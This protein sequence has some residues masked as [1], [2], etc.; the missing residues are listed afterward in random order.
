MNRPNNRNYLDRPR[1]KAGWDGPAEME[2]MR[3]FCRTD[4][5]TFFLYAFGA[6]TNPKGQR[7][8]DPEVHE[9]LARWFQKHVEE[10]EGWRRD[11]VNR[12]KKLAVVV[13]REIGKTTLIT[14]AGQ[15]WL[16]LRDP[17][18][19][20]ATGSEKVELASKMMEAMKAVLDGS[21]GHALWTRL[22]GDWSSAARKWTGKEVVHA[23]RRNTS[24]QDPSFIVFGVETSITGSHPDAIFYDDP[25][26]YERLT[27][28]SNWLGAVNSQVSSLIPVLQ[29]DGLLVWPGTRYDDEDHYGVAFK[30]EGVI[31]VSGMQTGSIPLDPDGAVHVYFLAAR[32]SDGTPTTPKVWSEERLRR[33]QKADPLRY[34]SQVMNDPSI[35]ELNP[36]TRDQI[37]QCSVEKKDVPWHSLR[38]AL[39]CDTAFSDGNK[40]SGKDETVMVVHGYP[41]NGS[42][43]VYVI[44]GFGNTTLRAEDFGKLLVSTVQRYRRQGLK[45]IAITDEKTRAGKKDAWRLTLQ[46]F[47]ADVNEPMPRFIEFERGSTKKYERLHSASTFWVDGHVR[48]VKGAPGNDRLTEQMARIG[49]YAVNPRIKIDWVDAHSDAFQKELYSPMRRAGEATPWDRGASPLPGDGLM[50]SDFDDDTSGDWSNVVPR[51]PIR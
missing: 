39:C 21:D 1:L 15:L 29:G 40:V 24:R 32:D 11:G 14:R 28:D 51:P 2:L 44:E 46:N 22:F 5:W 7:W 9:P 18:I 10:W 27:S 23:G 8:I 38:Y 16:H 31:S 49:Q 45:I 36:I 48:W 3:H 17:E 41:R 37:A 4:F 6:G 26:S 34:A 42:G 12:Q 43:D 50:V 30:T 33:Y 47:F 19:A 25:I 20:T 13:Q 35:S